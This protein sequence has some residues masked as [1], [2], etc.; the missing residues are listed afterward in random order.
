MITVS[1]SRNMGSVKGRE[2][3]NLIDASYASVNNLLKDEIKIGTK[4]RIKTDNTRVE[5]HRGTYYLLYVEEMGV[6][7]LFYQDVS[8]I[9][10]TVHTGSV[11]NA[12]SAV[13]YNVADDTDLVILNGRGKKAYRCVYTFIDS[14]GCKKLMPIKIMYKNKSSKENPQVYLGLYEAIMYAANFAKTTNN[15]VSVITPKG[16]ILVEFRR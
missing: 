15:E 7:Y 13:Y 11:E 1:L 14:N 3:S 9:L 8:G 5:K 2:K 12:I 16:T 4:V 10:R 6:A